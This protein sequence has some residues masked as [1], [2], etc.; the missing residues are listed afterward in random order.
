MTC[1]ISREDVLANLNWRYAVKKFAPNKSISAE[2]W[3]S[4]KSALLL[5]PSSYGLQPWHFFVVDDKE[6]RQKLLEVSNGQEKVVSSSHLL[7]FAA[8][9]TITEDDIRRWVK[10]LQEVRNLSPD[11][12]NKMFQTMAN[13]LVHG[14]R[15]AEAGQWAKRQTYLALG[16]FLSAAAFLGI[17][18]CP[19][20]G[21]DPQ[22]YDRILKLNEKGYTAAV[23]ATA[24]YRSDQDKTAALPKARFHPADVFTT[25]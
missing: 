17:D 12:S 21:F 7:V 18:T 3:A 14:P 5:S 6:T 25:V 19:M 4:L 20:E 8:R 24:G 23:I 2:D 15:A 22:G 16:V 1:T 9:T 13:D 11:D 10:R